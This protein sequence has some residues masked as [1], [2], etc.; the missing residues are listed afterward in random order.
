MPRKSPIRH[1]VMMHKRQGKIVQSFERGK[2]NR[3]QRS[4]SVTTNLQKSTLRGEFKDGKKLIKILNSLG[5][6]GYIVGGSVRDLI[7]GRVGDDVDIAT[8]ATPDQV[9]K[10]FS[11]RG[12]GIALVGEK[13]GTVLVYKKGME[14]IEI[15]TYRSEGKYTDSRHPDEVRFEK[16]LRKDLARRDL[17]I[18]SMAYNPVTDELIDPYGGRNDIKNKL[19]RAVGNPDH[20]F[21]EDPLRMLRTVRFAGRLG[22]NIEK[23]TYNSMK[24]NSGELDWLPVERVKTELFKILEQDDPAS[25]LQIL[26]D[27]KLMDRFLPEVSNLQN[28]EQPQRYHKYNVFE[29]TINTVSAVSK[30]KP[31]LRFAALVHDIGK[32]RMRS[33]SPFFPMHAKASV[34]RFEEISDRLKLSNDER[35][36]VRFMV[37]KHM[38]LRQADL[39]ERSMRGFLN[40]SLNA[41][42]V[43]DL[44]HLIR[45]DI[46]GTG[47]T[48]RA[49][50]SGMDR[51]EGLYHKVINEKQPF[52]KKDLKISGHDIMSLGVPPSRK[53]GEIQNV[54]LS[55]VLNDPRLNTK[56]YLLKRVKELSSRA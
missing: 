23:D 51:A 34:D 2:G 45:A 21:T 38:N 42:W 56:K 37:E 5:F 46:K 52:S 47:Y 15:T 43:P 29:H 3:I 27:T 13:F 50:L 19:I 10:I 32:E 36:Y 8:N 12:Y 4:K 16:D 18:N 20:R 49:A 26:A 14:P 48:S 1:R 9:K 53:I 6:E 28:I 7:L 25:S 54:L 44:I 55:E 22:F 39:N 40:K 24:R 30:N 41:D 11:E 17:T 31:L 33:E 35:N